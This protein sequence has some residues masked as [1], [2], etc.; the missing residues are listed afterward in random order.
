MVIVQHGEYTEYHWI[1]HFKVLN[2]ILCEFYH[3]FLKKQSV[4]C[5]RTVFKEEAE[6]ATIILLCAQIAVGIRDSVFLY[7]YF[8]GV[9][10]CVLR[11]WVI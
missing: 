7:M 5:K 3:G 11:T 6:R 2:F 4:K 8:E 1:T 9:C 10:V